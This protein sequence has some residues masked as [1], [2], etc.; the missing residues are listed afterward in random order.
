MSLTKVLK[1]GLAAAAA[2]A[3]YNVIE[4]HVVLFNNAQPCPGELKMGSKK[5]G[6]EMPVCPASGPSTSSLTKKEQNMIL[7]GSLVVAV[8]AA[9]AL[10]GSTE[11]R[12][13]PYGFLLSCK[14]WVA[15]IP[16]SHYE[17]VFDF[18]K[19][20]MTP[21][22]ALVLYIVDVYFLLKT[23]YLNKVVVHNAHKKYVAHKND[24]IIAL[25]GIG[26]ATELTLGTLAVIA[27]A[28][29]SVASL[30]PKANWLEK[31][32]TSLDPYSKGLC[33]ASAL[34]G[35]LINVPSGLQLTPGV[36]GIKSL[37]VPGFYKFAAL[38]TMEASRVLFIDHRL[39]TNMWILLKVGTVVRLLGYYILPYTSAD[40]QVPGDLFTEP[41]I[42]SQNILL[43]GVLTA[44]FVYP[45]KWVLASMGV[46][47]AGQY[48]H[49]PKVYLRTRFTVAEK[50]CN[51]NDFE[52]KQIVDAGAESSSD[53]GTSPA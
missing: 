9:G 18:I 46:Y 6:A 21:L 39:Y 35:V 19:S 34:L 23:Y 47:V 53:D 25:H 11:K 3:A 49:P 52:T 1:W 44:G 51:P 17:P 40:R 36:Y 8:V 26:S 37:T 22:M 50:E 14:E 20:P 7:D 33:I 24:H 43:S 41:A 2:A 30:G 16:G 29:K 27:L 5:K 12:T 13:S 32:A 45:P 15:A 28:G 31:L 10:F 4:K 48:T 38:R 42:Y